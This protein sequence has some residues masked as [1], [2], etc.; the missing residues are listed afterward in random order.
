[1]RLRLSWVFAG[2]ASVAFAQLGSVAGPSAGYVFD[3]AARTVRQIRGIAG[4]ATMGDTVDFG[5]AILTAEISP[6]GDL[7]IATAADG[8]LH[9]FKLAGST[10]TEL[11]NL[12][13]GAGAAMAVFS[14]NGSAAALQRADG[15]QVLRGLPDAPEVAF[16]A[17]VRTTMFQASTS[18]AHIRATPSAAIAVSDDGS[19]VLRA[20]D[21]EIAVITSAGTRKLADARP[22]ASIAFAPGG[23]DAA[24]NNGG[25][26]TVFQ[27]VTG[28]ATGQ[29][30][31]NVGAGAM[32]FSADGAKLL[33]AGLRAVT[34]LD[35]ATADRKLATCECKIGGLVRMGAMLRLNEPG[36]GPLWLLDPSQT[37][38]RILFVPAR[39]L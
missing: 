16:T 28:A 38:P 35:R 23:R 39:P 24:I 30:F 9:F 11:P 31:Q 33:V 6:R 20:G 36:S 8:S 21:G 22:N 17:P 19:A 2:V 14:P 34:V 12:N 7:A 18:A 32:A 5:M 4:A 29:D 3:P 27:D 13:L 10:A 25:T 37:E 26:V 1:M 15:I